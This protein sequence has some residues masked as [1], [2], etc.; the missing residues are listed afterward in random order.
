MVEVV[1]SSQKW[2]IYFMALLS[3]FTDG[4]KICDEKKNESNMT[5]SFSA[6]TR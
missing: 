5:P 3:V 6:I 4:M 1:K 2:D